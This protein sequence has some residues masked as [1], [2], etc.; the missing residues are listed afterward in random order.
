MI[1]IIIGLIVLLVIG[2]VVVNGIQQHKQKQDQEKRAQ[3]AKFKAIIDESDELI[4]SLSAMPPS[5]MLVNIL[6][7][8]SFNAAKAMLQISPDSKPVKQRVQELEAQLKATSE[9]ASAQPSEENFVLPD[10]EQQLVS[11]LQAIKKLRIMLKSEQSKGALD[12]QSY[13]QQDLRLDAMQ[14]KIGVESLLSRGQKAYSK[15]ML[16]SAR[17]YFEKALQTLKSHP[18]QTE[19]TKTKIEQIE[20]QLEE[21]TKALVNTNAEDAAKKAKDEEDD[22]DML[23]QPKKKW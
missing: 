18:H 23:F 10:N 20:D 22:L 16:G 17:Q 6:Y 13:T 15:E 2:V 19:Y 1:I 12:P 3:A 4:L 7:R 21:I 11:I 14:L 5:P 8:R 9:Q